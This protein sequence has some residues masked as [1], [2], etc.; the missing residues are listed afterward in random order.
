MSDPDVNTDPRWF[1]QL[2]ESSPDPT[3]I[4]DRNRFVECNQAAITTLGYANRDALLNVHPSE[5]SPPCQPD[6]EVS[7]IKAERMLALALQQGLH[8]FD[9]MH[10]KADGTDFLAEVT[11]SV[12]KLRDRQLIHCVWRDITERKRT[13]EQLLRQNNL[14]SAV[15]ENFPGAISVVGADL[16][17][18]AHNRQFKTL[19]EFPDW[20]IDKPGVTFEDIVRFNAQRGDYGAGDPE[21]HVAAV[22]A[23]VSNLQPH[24]FERVRPNGTVL[25][26]RGMPMPGG[27]F[28]TTYIDI[29]AR[30]QAEQEI[31]NLAFH[32]ALTRLPNRRLLND[33]LNQAM[34]ASKR[35]GGC[36]ALMFLDLDHFKPLNDK[37]G[38]EVG[39]LLLIEVASR[40]SACVRQVDTVARFGGD[41]FVVLLGDLPTSRDD[42]TARA[43]LIAEKIRLSLAQ[44]YLLTRQRAGQADARIEHHCTV[45]MGVAVFVNHEASPDDLLKWA[46]M[47]MYESKESGRNTV[48]YHAWRSTGD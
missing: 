16:R 2:F 20:L 7:Y 30:K 40:L 9:W 11:L 18:A 21:K 26:I 31:E 46:D 3:W 13:E 32:D 35:S 33:R 28:V 12:V 37:H 6:G 22:L 29:T 8:R 47:A 27:G 10:R 41:E 24:K 15:I 43:G 17:V 5:L 36:G 44:P 1:K 39:D 42:A 14:L 25:E 34:A 19:L 48:R 4:I 45:S 38:H 23:R